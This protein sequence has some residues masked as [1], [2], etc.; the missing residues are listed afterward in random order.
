V[1]STY[2]SIFYWLDS[3]PCGSTT[4]IA[5]VVTFILTLIATAIITFI[6]TYMIVKRKD[7]KISEGISSKHPVYDTVV[8]PSHTT[9]DMELHPNPAYDT[10][11]KVKMDNNPA[12]KSYKWLHTDTLVKYYIMWSHTC[13]HYDAVTLTHV[14]TSI[15]TSYWPIFFFLIIVLP[16][17]RII[18]LY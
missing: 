17:L 3:L 11:D 15:H 10:S 13:T 6:V 4:A 14:R 7:D 5:C 2:V 18:P 12:Y 1:D 8:P 9:N 16:L